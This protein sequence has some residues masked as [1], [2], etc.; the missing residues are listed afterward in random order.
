MKKVVEIDERAVKEID[1]FCVEVQMRITTL[2][3]ALARDG[4]LKEP[5]GKRINK[6]IFEIR[7]KYKGQFRALYAYLVKNKVII[8]T[9]FQ[10]KKQKTPTKEIK[11]AEKRL[12]QYK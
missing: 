7:V 4:F 12:A 1:Q 2:L 6:D 11:K 8:L 9:A 5:H 10:K 3:D